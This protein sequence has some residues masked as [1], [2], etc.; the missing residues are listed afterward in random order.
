LRFFFALGRS[1][2]VDG[3]GIFLIRF[4]GIS[5]YRATGAEDTLLASDEIRLF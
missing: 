1:N 3:P 4:Q 5:R 2:P